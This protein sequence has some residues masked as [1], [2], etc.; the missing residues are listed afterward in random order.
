MRRT[1]THTHTHTHSAVYGKVPGDEDLLRA[2]D[3]AAPEAARYGPLFGAERRR[4][5]RA[6]LVVGAGHRVADERR[7]KLLPEEREAA[8]GARAA[9]Q[10]VGRGA[11]ALA[12]AALVE[13]GARRRAVLPALA[14]DGVERGHE[15]RR[16]VGHEAAARHRRLVQV[17]R[18]L[19]LETRVPVRVESNRR[20][21][22]RRAAHRR[23]KEEREEKYD[24]NSTSRL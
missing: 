14:A 23:E 19:V 9:A 2:A 15:V 18:V 20:D 17:H 13:A 11:G 10:N 22:T 1:G 4:R 12:S 5:R 8:A 16:A 3:G 6:R 24:T 21:A 7:Q